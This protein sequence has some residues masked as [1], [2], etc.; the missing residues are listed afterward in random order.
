MSCRRDGNHDAAIGTERRPGHGLTESDGAD[1]P[2]VFPP[3]PRGE[4]GGV[5]VEF[6]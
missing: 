2:T 4:N 1:D 3:P 6:E 5:I